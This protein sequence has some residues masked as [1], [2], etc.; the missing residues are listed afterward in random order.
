MINLKK[1]HIFPGCVA[2]V[3]SDSL[4]S[5][6]WHLIVHVL[7]AGI[8]V[9]YHCSKG[10]G[11]AQPLTSAADWNSLAF[12]YDLETSDNIEMK[13]IQLSLT[14]CDYLYVLSKFDFFAS[15]V[16]ESHIKLLIAVFQKKDLQSK[17]ANEVDVLKI[18]CQ[19]M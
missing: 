12:T 1:N 17:E 7:S 13:N 15:F 6:R 18:F 10:N 2:C 3:A 19:N 8:A 9:I 14:F 4:C 16:K 11:L 5:Q